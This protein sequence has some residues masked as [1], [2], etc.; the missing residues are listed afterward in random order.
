MKNLFARDHYDDDDTSLAAADWRAKKKA[1]TL[2]NTVRAFRVNDRVKVVALGQDFHFF[3]GE[4][5]IVER[6]EDKH[7][8][9]H[10]RFDPPRRFEGGMLQEFFGF[11]PEDLLVIET[12]Q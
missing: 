1:G 3:F 6:V 7:L 12:A 11:D 5:A 10:V 4:E 8:G 2:G 9:I